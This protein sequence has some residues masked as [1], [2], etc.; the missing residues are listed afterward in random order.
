MCKQGIGPNKGAVGIRFTIFNTS[1]CLICSHLAA[2][3]DKVKVRNDNFNKIMNKLKF[4]DHHND[5]DAEYDDECKNDREESISRTKS[6]RQPKI[7]INSHDLIFFFGDLNY[8]LDADNDTIHEL[9]RQKKWT[10]L[11]QH[12]QLKNAIAERK[13][14]S[15]HF[16]EHSIEF[17]PTYKYIPN[18]SGYDK[19]S[20]RT[21]SYC[22]RILW[23]M[24]AK[25]R[26]SAGKK[27][28]CLMYTA[29]N[30]ECMSDHKPVVGRFE[31]NCPYK[32][33]VII[34]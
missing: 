22:D 8:R 10:N 14:F 9:I 29:F 26:M 24:S 16:E 1:I 7:L 18:G 27:L 20:N 4:R 30:K 3:K 12:D 33:D 13:A 19:L 5:H 25:K 31:I 21:P 6:L 23:R 28:E 17:R 32:T 15:E 11:L 34:T 2:H